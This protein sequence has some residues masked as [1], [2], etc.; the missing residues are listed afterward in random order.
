MMT[1][2][3]LSSATIHDVGEMQVQFESDV[4]RARNIG[5]LLAQELKF[6][7]T[8]CIRIGTTVSELCRNMIEHAG[9]GHV[10]F[11]IADRVIDSEGVVIIFSDKGMGIQ[12]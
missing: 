4:V 12:I 9:G 3:F 6:D 5:L 1:L 2:P 8:T 10:A 7:N 11:K